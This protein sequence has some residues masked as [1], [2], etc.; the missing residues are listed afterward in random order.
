MKNRPDKTENQSKIKNRGVKR[1]RNEPKD[2][3][4]LKNNQEVQN[5][6]RR[7]L[8]LQKSKLTVLYAN[9]DFGLPNKLEELKQRIALHTPDVVSIVEVIPK[10]ATQ[11]LTKTEINLEGYELVTNIE[12]DNIRGIVTYVK[13]CI[14]ISEKDFTIQSVENKWCSIKLRGQDKLLLGNIYRSPNHD[15]TNQLCDLLKEVKE[16]KPSH[17]LITGDFNYREIQWKDGHVDAP[18][19]HIAHT[20]YDTVQDLYL[21]QHVE[22]YTRYREGQRPSCLDLVLTNESGLVSNL[23]YLPG[24]GNSDHVS[25]LFDVNIYTNQTKKKTENYAYH[26]GDYEAIRKEMNDVNWE[27][28][29]QDKDVETAWKLFME[30]IQELMEKYI[31]KCRTKKKKP[32][33]N[34]KAEQLMKKKYHLWKKYVESGNS[35]DLLNFKKCKNFLRYFTRQLKKEFEKKI[36]KEAKKNPKPFWGYAN[37]KLKTRSK[38]TQL[39]KKDG[40]MTENDQE[41]AET[42]NEFFSSVFTDENTSNIPNMEDKSNGHSISEIEIDDKTIEKKLNKLKPGKA[43]GPDGI[44]PTFLKE[45]A[46]NISKPLAIIFNKSIKEGTLP[47]DWKKAHVTAIHKKSSKQEPGNYRPISLTSVCCKIMEAIIRDNVV[48]YMMQNKMFADQQHGFVPNRSCI[49]QLLCVIEEWTQWIENNNCFDTIFLDFQKAFDSVPHERLMVKLASYGIKGNLAN[50]I[51]NFLTGRKQRVVIED[52][53]SN[54]TD[55]KSGVPQGSVLGPLLFVIYINDLPEAVK[56]TVKI[57][58]DDTKLYRKVNNKED[59]V[60]MQNDLGKLYKW[61]LEWQIQFNASKCKVMH[62][63]KKNI[64]ETY[65]INGTI[66]EEVK[67]EKD[68]GVIIDNELKFHKHVSQAV[69]KANQILGVVNNT[70]EDLDKESFLL[71]YKHQV[72]P[73]IEYGNIIWHPHYVMDIKKIEGVQRRAT[74]LVKNIRNMP[75]QERLKTLNLFSMEYRRKRGDM[76]QVYKILNEL[77][78]VDTNLFFTMAHY[79]RTR[80]NSKKIYRLKT[81]MK[82]VREN[83]FSQR[84]ITDWNSLPEDVVT[85][86]SVDS[87]KSRLDKFWRD[88]WFKIS[89]EP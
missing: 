20:F 22:E 59:A 87:F 88:H 31:P 82:K 24:L 27:E 41:K 23:Q 83:V 69:K 40:K 52:E 48:N 60:N 15:N 89:T 11:K 42:L 85:A 64:K 51:K 10:L 8:G 33:I 44:H 3:N 57:F 72:R 12:K 79:S 25:L 54:W 75:Y 18:E 6:T 21:I 4:L 73:H 61:S 29:L 14:D 62:H 45:T 68:L 77:D 19:K 76:I 66:L 36:L 28:L 47:Q 50:W 65:E 39:R 74:H 70:F 84:V 67:E 86:E 80:Q 49:T 37:S 26:K 58:A 81:S 7:P 16:H 5:N 78:R 46:K 63:G 38:I 17:L 9:A 34:R 43:A 2:K 13:D 1:M 56:S 30:K 71:A 32:Y 55:V 35:E 53:K